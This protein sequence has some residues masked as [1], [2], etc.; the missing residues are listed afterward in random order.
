MA[1]HVH[2]QRVAVP[3]SDRPSHPTV[4][5]RRARVLHVNRSN[6]VCKLIRNHDRIRTLDDLKRLRHISGAR[7][8][9]HVALD[10]RVGSP[11]IFEI[12]IALLACAGQVGDLAALHNARTRRHRA[13]RSLV[14]DPAREP[15]HGFRDS[16]W[17]CLGLATRR[18][19]RVCDS[20][21]GGFSI[22]GSDPRRS[23]PLATLRW[24]AL[25][26]TNTSSK[27]LLQPL[28]Y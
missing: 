23:P 9:W 4:S 25:L 5:R 15:L 21:F 8:A 2:H 11:A 7:H 6:R 18:S 17:Q 19:D 10:L 22:R 27:E 28:G 26:Q 3:M 13:D 1:G 20:V 14:P 24:R 12:L 16:N